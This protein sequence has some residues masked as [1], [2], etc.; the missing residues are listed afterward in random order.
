MLFGCTLAENGYLSFVKVGILQ[1]I[2]MSTNEEIYLYEICEILWNHTAT[3]IVKIFLKEAG[4]FF[5]SKENLFRTLRRTCLRTEI[6]R[7]F[8]LNAMRKKYET[9]KLHHF[10]IK[11]LV[12]ST[13]RSLAK[14]YETG[15]KKVS[16]RDATQLKARYLYKANESHSASRS[17][18]NLKVPENTTSQHQLKKG[19]NDD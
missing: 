19:I 11:S 15:F 6:T 13:P 2:S 7:V 8:I 14:V 1:H 9:N 3:N 10:F 4:F 17:Q 5:E 18:T 16:L 12:Y